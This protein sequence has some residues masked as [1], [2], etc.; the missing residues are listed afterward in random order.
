MTT[1][2]A[3]GSLFSAAEFRRR[4]AAQNPHF[5]PDDYGDHRLNPDLK[6]LILQARLRD[7]AVLVP[8]VDRGDKSTVILTQRKTSPPSHSGHIPF[9]CCRIE[10]TYL[11]PT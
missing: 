9:L 11:T 6:D 7:A 4:A 5:A 8:V 10:P 1:E 2:A 3:T